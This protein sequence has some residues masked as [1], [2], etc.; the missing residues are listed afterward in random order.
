MVVVDQSGTTLYTFS[1]AAS[2]N[3]VKNF[4]WM[5]SAWKSL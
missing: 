1:S 4:E 5:G 3:T 2:A